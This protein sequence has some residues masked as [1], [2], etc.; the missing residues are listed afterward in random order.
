MDT[1]VVYTNEYVLRKP[2]FVTEWFHSF[3]L[4]INMQPFI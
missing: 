3:I 1:K 4:L 2:L